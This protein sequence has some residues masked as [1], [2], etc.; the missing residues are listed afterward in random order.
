MKSQRYISKSFRIA[1][2]LSNLEVDNK[3]N[4]S[5][6]I[7][8]CSFV[9][10]IS[11]N[12]RSYWTLLPNILV[13]DVDGTQGQQPLSCLEFPEVLLG[14]DNQSHNIYW[15]KNGKERAERGNSYLVQLIESSGGGNY[16]CHNT[17]GSLLNYTEVLIRQVE[18]KR[19]RILVKTA[20][21]DYLK[22]SAQNYNGDFQCSWTWHSSRVGKVAF[23]KVRRAS[24]ENNTQCSVDAS[25]QHW[26]CSSVHS[27]FSC[28][29]DSNGRGIYCRDEQH[30][31]YAEEIQ[32]IH[33]TIDVR[34]E[35]FLLES[36]ST[37][38]FLS[39]IVKPD[40]VIIGKVNTTVVEWSYPNSWNRPHSYFPLTF[41]IAQLRHGCRKCDD[42]C[43]DSNPTK[44]SDFT[45]ICQYKVKHSAKAVCVRAK[46]A[47]CN[48]QWS[49][50]S[51]IRLG[52]NK[53]NKKKN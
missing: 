45:D 33:I 28:S 21:E 40:K 11:P 18:T 37:L 49:E 13:V 48:S 39:E 44:T 20:E 50:W 19:W 25:N 42:P 7:L 30:C 43:T 31:P 9:Q 47:L 29:V 14:R 52:R 22:C 41:Q 5:F 3:M 17:E 24:D 51:H 35:H 16:T 36:Y 23:I 32:Q 53:K 27:N 26:I 1:G 34:T 4:L 10:V 2:V 46:D 38:F 12:P 6:F 15:K 8:I